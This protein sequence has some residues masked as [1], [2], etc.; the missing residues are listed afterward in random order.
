MLIYSKENE[1]I[2]LIF[3]CLHMFQN[4]QISYEF[5]SIKDYFTCPKISLHKI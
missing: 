1:Q 4:A 3:S 5:Y 2:Q